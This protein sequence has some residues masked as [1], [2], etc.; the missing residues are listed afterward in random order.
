MWIDSAVTLLANP[1]VASSV[2]PTTINP[3]GY[4]QIFVNGSGFL[5]TPVLR[6]L[7]AATPTT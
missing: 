2:T 7:N 3:S 1:P 5:P 4:T 6:L